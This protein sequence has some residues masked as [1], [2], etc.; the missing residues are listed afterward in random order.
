MP[1]PWHP[2]H[3]VDEAEA[4]PAPARR[5]RLSRRLAVIGL[6]GLMLALPAA[7]YAN[8][9]FSDV[10]TSNTFHTPISVLYGSRI[11]GG[12]GSG[13]YCPNAAVTRGQ[14]AAF[15]VRGL[16]RMA[17]TIDG[18]VG[19]WA[20]VTGAP[21]NPGDPHPFG[22]AAPLTFVH[23]GGV[24]GTAYVFATGTVQVFTSETGVCPC[25]VQAFLFNDTTGE[26]SQFFFGMIGS[27]FAPADPDLPSGT[28]FAETTVS[29]S[30]AFSVDSGVS[31]D[32]GIALKVIPSNP[33][34]IDDTDGN[35]TG[36]DA[37]LQ[38]VYVP[39][40]ETGGNPPGPPATQGGKQTPRSPR[41]VI[42]K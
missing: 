21:V 36:W 39:F 17:S 25:E 8:H 41:I 38:T 26:I 18:N 28:A 30:Y 27:D 11:T 16:G 40:N 1:L 35:I 31:N 7:V 4:P 13:K 6:A 33:Q 10:P 42:T 34:T 32:Y 29:L 3:Q 12:C 20:D 22:V 14:M 5:R 37:T 19:D 2:V 9:I 24:G 15:L 23:G